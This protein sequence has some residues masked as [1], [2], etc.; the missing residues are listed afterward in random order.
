MGGFAACLE[1]FGNKKSL[2]PNVLSHHRPTCRLSFMSKMLEKVVFNQLQTFSDT[3]CEVTF[4]S[5][6]LVFCSAVLV[7]LDLIAAFTVDHHNLGD[8]NMLLMV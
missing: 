3:V 2:D 1:G 5:F 8:L 6:L 4:K 7:L